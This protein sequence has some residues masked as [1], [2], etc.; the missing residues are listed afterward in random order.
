MSH[1]IT[2]L[3]VPVRTR[4][5]PLYCFRGGA[6]GYLFWALNYYEPAKVSGFPETDWPVYRDYTGVLADGGNFIPPWHLDN[7]WQK[8]ETIGDGILLYPPAPGS[9]EPMPCQRMMMW[10]SG[11]EDYE[12]LAELKR[13]ME[14]KGD[15]IPQETRFRM[16]QLFELDNI[17]VDGW[18]HPEMVDQLRAGIGDAINSLKK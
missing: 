17:L 2:L 8:K 12:Y 5:L 7:P 16:E 3:E 6:E 1:G 18:E 14:E 11:M 4:L 10:R 9:T 13:L 15:E